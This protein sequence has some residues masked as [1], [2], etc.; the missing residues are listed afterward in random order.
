MVSTWMWKLATMVSTYDGE[1]VA[2]SVVEEDVDSV[3]S[4]LAAACSLS[5]S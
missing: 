2:V 4:F 5:R 3:T 1:V